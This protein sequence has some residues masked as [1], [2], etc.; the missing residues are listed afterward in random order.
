MRFV[1]QAEVR[2]KAGDGGRGCASFAQP[3]YT[4]YPSP[5]GG[6]GGDGGNVVLL[7]DPN[8]ATLLDFHFRHEFAAGR[9]GHG[10]SNTKTGKR[11]ADLVIHVPVGTVVSDAE[12]GQVLRDLAVA[13]EQAVVAKGGKGGFGNAAAQEAQPGGAG[14]RRRLSLELKLIADVGLVGF[15]NAGKSSLLARVSTARPKIAAYPFT[16]RYPVLG[17]V[18]AGDRGS[19]VACDVPGLIEEAHRGKGLGIQ[20]LRHI[21]RTRLLWHVVDLAGVDGRDPVAAY[22]QLNH[23]LSAYGA[24]LEERP[25]MVV[26]NKMDL[27]E[28]RTALPA[29]ERAVGARVWPVSAATGEGLKPLLDAAWQEL[30]QL[31]S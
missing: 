24:G 7:T 29:F 26:A 21:E 30:Q 6:D 10:G 2:V 14:E 28:A 27:A 31:T 5:D 22:H 20:F 15:P 16:T 23:E 13:R 19:F 25:Q 3:P 17:V 11:G 18:H 12:T 1:D 9:G 4:R 8:V